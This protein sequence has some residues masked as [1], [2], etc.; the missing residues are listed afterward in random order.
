MPKIFITRKIPELA[1]KM[2]RE[3]GYEVEV[4]QKGDALTHDELIFAL[5]AKPYDAVLC[6]L[7]DKIDDL[8]LA[9]A[10]SAKIFANYA[11][12]YDNID[13]A[14][15]RA[16]GVAV[17]NTPAPSTSQSVAE[18]ALA[19]VVAV[20]R[21]IVEADQFVR[22]GG[23]R[24][25]DPLLFLTPD[26][27]GRTLGIIGAGRI[28]SRLAFHAARGFEM[29]VIYHD[30]KRN[31]KI[32]NELGAEARPSVEAVLGEADYVS[33]HVNLDESTRHLLNAERLALMKASAV[34]V[35]TARG[36]VVDEAALVTALRE[37]KIAGAGLDVFEHEPELAPGLKDLPNVVLTP[38]IAS[39]T[40]ETR[41]DMA[42]MA[43][44][45]IIAALSGQPPPNLIE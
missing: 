7:T 32:E 22:D 39:A 14:A 41:D 45:N 30:L 43:A 4:S 29:K 5:Q 34:L 25:W 20:G 18:H 27:V 2:L 42:R 38:H 12:G 26:L 33:L 24:N 15:A 23:Y 40:L 21:R 10:P 19:L 13:L 17:S 44:Q 9:A 8:V 31:E 28:G 11:V 37:K 35:N 3:K 36:A 6:L 1:E 16:R